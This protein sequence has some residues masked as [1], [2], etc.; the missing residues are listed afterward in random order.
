MKRHMTIYVADSD[1][2]VWE[3]AKVHA[4]EL[5]LSLSKYII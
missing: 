2:D 5:G 3:R 4:E 1:F